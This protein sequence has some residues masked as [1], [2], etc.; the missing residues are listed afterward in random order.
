VGFFTLLSLST[1]A[2]TNYS[3]VALV[4]M[5]GIGF[6][7][8]NIALSAFLFATA[9]GVLAAVSSPTRRSGTGRRRGRIRCRRRADPDGRL[10]RSRAA[11]LVLAMGSAG[12]LSGMIS[13]SR[14]MLVRAAPRPARSAV[15]SGSS[16]PDST[17]AARSA[18]DRRM[19]H[20][21]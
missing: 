8:A 6:E 2:L 11:V 9:V 12:F 5:D 17:S 16:R 20:G 13:P 4:R 7:T 10:G 3:A 21:P 18:D 1:G 19:D 15:C 14:D